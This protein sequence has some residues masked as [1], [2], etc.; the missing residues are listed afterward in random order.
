MRSHTL[1]ILT[2][3]ALAAVA[4]LALGAAVAQTKGKKGKGKDPN[5]LKA[6]LKGKNEVPGPGDP[7]G[8]GKALIR[9]NAQAG[10]VCF[11]LRWK[12]IATPTAAHI[13]VGGK[14]D[15]GGIVVGLFQGTPANNGCVQSVDANLIRQIRDNPRGYYVNIHTGDFPNGAI[16]GQLKRTG[17][18]K[19]KFK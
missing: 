3:L 16:R 9:L 6:N 19:G 11:R 5:T 13:H 4:M 1:R 8:K 14:R 7:D 12:K 17:K 10:T 15:A 2:A 18:H